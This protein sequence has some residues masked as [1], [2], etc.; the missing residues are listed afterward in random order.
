LNE[1]RAGYTQNGSVV[2]VGLPGVPQIGFDDGTLGFGSYNGYPQTFHENIY[3]YTDLVSI[4]HGKHS[5]KAGTEFRRNLE[6]S[7]FN[8]GHPSYYFFDALFF[9]IDSPYTESAGVDPGIVSGTPAHLETS[10]RHWRNWEIGAYLQ[11]DWKISKRLTLNLGI[12]YDLTR[13]T[14]LNNLATTFLKGP[15][16]NF[17]DNIPTGAGQI[18]NASTPCP[19]DPLATIAGE[20]RP[21]G[22][23]PAK[24]LGRGDHNNFGPRVG[25]AWDV[26]GNGKTSLRG[27]FGVSYEGTLYN[28]LS[29]TRW[30]PPFYSFNGVSNSWASDVNDVVYGPV[31]GHQPTFLGPAPPAQH[32]GTGAQATG[33]ISGWDPS[34]LQLAFLS[35]IVFLKAFA[36]LTWRT[37]SSE[38]SRN[39]AIR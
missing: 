9:A 23:A 27:G 31:D 30:N 6:N 16:K 10:I 15:G 18:K 2:T 12:R 21:G 39:C 38:G 32:S 29:N 25:F 1:F 24:E 26:F 36:I 34:N 28:P 20:C 5:L 3:H 4:N 33:N 35:S 11:D 8:A 37:G 22:F 19:G 13:H 7:D 14:E 17:I